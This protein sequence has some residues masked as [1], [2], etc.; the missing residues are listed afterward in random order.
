MSSTVLW[1]IGGAHDTVAT[2][3]F[4]AAH[5]DNVQPIGAGLEGTDDLGRDAYNIPLTEVLS[6]PGLAAPTC[7]PWGSRRCAVRRRSP[8]V[9]A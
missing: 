7:P 5:G 8:P 9:R 2:L 3:G 6:T 1:P 4:G